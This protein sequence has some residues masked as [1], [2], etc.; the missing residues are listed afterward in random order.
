[1]NTAHYAG[2]TEII[3][4][5]LRPGEMLLESIKEAITKHDVGSGVVISG[6]GTLKTC[7]MHYV[8][9]TGFPSDN[10]FYTLEKPLELLSVSG[11]IADGEPHLHVVVSCKEEGVWGGHL[12]DS[13]EVLYLAE[14]AILKLK[15]L[16][17]TRTA[18][19]EFK[20][21]LLTQKQ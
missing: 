10:K 17:L 18:D 5:G 8:T 7:H 19:P 1:M 11:I 9:H 16:Q 13:C 14:I 12:E 3:T 21:K 15:D 4:I 20:T 6:V 2:A